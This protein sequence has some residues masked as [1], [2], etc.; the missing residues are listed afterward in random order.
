MAHPRVN[1]PVGAAGLVLLYA[2]VAAL[3]RWPDAGLVLAA[4]GGMLGWWAVSGPWY[5]EEDEN[6]DQTT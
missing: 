4:V 1:L 6:G 5:E 3:G 2:G